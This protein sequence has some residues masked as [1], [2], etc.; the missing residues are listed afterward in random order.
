MELCDCYIIVIILVLTGVILYRI[1]DNFTGGVRCGTDTSDASDLL[2]RLPFLD[3]IIYQN[4][5]AVNRR[6]YDI[7]NSY[8]MM[9]VGP[10]VNFHQKFNRGTMGCY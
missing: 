9:K 3:D 1:V 4:P 5:S 8:N 6:G 10:E 7:R 2:Q